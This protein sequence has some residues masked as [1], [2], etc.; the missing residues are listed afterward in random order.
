MN[1][2]MEVLK[3]NI[4][5]RKC[6]ELLEFNRPLSAILLYLE[7]IGGVISPQTIVSTSRTVYWRLHLYPSNEAYE[8]ELFRI[9]MLPGICSLI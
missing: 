8:V 3:N 2:Y 5:S 7:I 9:F 6:N 4:G 1:F